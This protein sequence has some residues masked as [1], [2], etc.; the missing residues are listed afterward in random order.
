MKMK[1]LLLTLLVPLVLFAEDYSRFIK[2]VNGIP[3]HCAWVEIPEGLLSSAIPRPALVYLHGEDEDG[4]IHRTV[5]GVQVDTTKVA[6]V[7][8]VLAHTPSKNNGMVIITIGACLG[9]RYRVNPVNEADLAQ[10]E[11]FLL[12]PGFGSDKWLD[13]D[14]MQALLPQG[15]NDE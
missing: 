9:D 15:E 8:F 10:W 12:P 4:N 6:L 3:V 2:T 11:S 7:D 13:K 1:T 5:K 14:E